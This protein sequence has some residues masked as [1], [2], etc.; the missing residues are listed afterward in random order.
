MSREEVIFVALVVMSILGWL[1]PW[2]TSVLFVPI[3]AQKLGGSRDSNRISQW[4]NGV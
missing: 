1:P 2:L 4:Y 3:H